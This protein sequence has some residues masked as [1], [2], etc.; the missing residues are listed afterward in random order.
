MLDAIKSS[1]YDSEGEDCLVNINSELSDLAIS[2]EV[3]L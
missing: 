2:L 3:N 1:E